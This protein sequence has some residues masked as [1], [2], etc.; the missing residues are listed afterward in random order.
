LLV[1]SLRLPQLFKPFTVTLDSAVTHT[2][3]GVVYATRAGVGARVKLYDREDAIDEMVK[4]LSVSKTG[5]DAVRITYRGSDSLT[6][7][8]V[9]NLMTAVYMVRRKTVD[10]GLNQ[11]RL[12]FMVAKSDT[13]RRDLDR[14]TDRLAAVAERHGAGASADIAAKALADQIGTV[15]AQIS[16]FRAAQRALDSLI[17]A[18]RGHVMDARALAGFPDLLRSPALN[19]LISQIAKIETEHTMLLAQAPETS[20]R[21]MALT[22]ARDSLT[23]Q[24]MPIASAYQHSLMRQ[25]RSLEHDRDSLNAALQKLPAAAAAVGKQ[26]AEVTRLAQLDMGMGAQVLQARLAAMR[27]GGDVRLVDPAMP[28]RRAA[29][30]R[31]LITMA[32]SLAVGLLFGIL[33]LPIGAAPPSAAARGE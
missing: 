8:Q 33:L 3:G 30:P 10:R 19:D 21:A 13:V 28:Q 11:R 23:A 32:V 26:Q 31:P 17:G 4:R 15:E 7:A 6:A 25:E 16:Q 18:A 2:H 5:G 1:D 12:E 24:I 27:E 20:P 9:P 29:F 22:R 14:A